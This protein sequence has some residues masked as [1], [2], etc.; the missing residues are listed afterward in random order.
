VIALVGLFN[1][2]GSIASGWLCTHYPQRYLLFGIC[3]LRAAVVTIFL[4]LPPTPT[5]ALIFGAAMGLLW[6]SATPPVTGLI[7]A[8]FGIRNLAALFGVAYLVHQVG[9][10]LGVWLGG[11]IYERVGSHEAMLWCLAVVGLTGAA[12]SLPISET[13]EGGAVGQRS[14][15]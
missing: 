9:A 13:S 2:F 10:F 4:I 5:V 1:I 6:L 8:M 15:K 7:V 14:N 11:L 3:I 12:L